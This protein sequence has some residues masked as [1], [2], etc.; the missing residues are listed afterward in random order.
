[1]PRA[2]HPC[3]AP[4]C[5]NPVPAGQH[6]CPKHHT[7]ADRRRGT[8]RQRG[9]D[10]AHAKRFRT[11]VL[12]RD[13]TCTCTPDHPAHEGQACTQP[14]TVADHHPRDRRQLVAEGL[15]PHDPQHGR[16]LCA[17]C[18]GWQTARHQPGGWNTNNP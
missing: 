13:P 12:R 6:R 11:R 5:P 10:T 8:A 2:M 4:G 15:D 18:H 7:E 16:G 3:P 17:S 14:S 9:Y 1:M